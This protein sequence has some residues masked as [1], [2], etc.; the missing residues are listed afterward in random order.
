MLAKK[1]FHAEIGIL[2]RACLETL[3]LLKIA[4]EDEE[5]I[6]IFVQSDDRKRLT[7]MHVAHKYKE[8]PFLM[9]KECATPEIMKELKEKIETV[10][11]QLLKV[12]QIAA[13]AGMSQY[14]D[15]VYR[16]FSDFVHTMPKSLEKFIEVDDAGDV[17]R[18]IHAPSDEDNR[19]YLLTLSDI[20]LRT[21]DL[22]F[23]L[24]SIDKKEKM[25][26]L[27]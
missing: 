14:Y 15:S 13:K 24:F 7:L 18:I 27:A 11:I 3:F 1:G 9:T 19:F 16:L 5:F 17:I 4:V 8:K 21:L 23:S 12:E 25:K 20:L 10:N 22:V 6:P 26:K 2:T